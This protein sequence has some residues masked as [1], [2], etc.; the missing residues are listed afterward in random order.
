MP[1]KQDPAFEGHLAKT[2]QKLKQRE[3][4][5]QNESKKNKRQ[6]QLV[7]MRKDLE[8]F[9]GDLKN[10]SKRTY[11]QAKKNIL[12]SNAKNLDSEGPQRA[13]FSSILFSEGRPDLALAL[14]LFLNENHWRYIAGRHASFVRFL[15]NEYPPGSITMTQ[16]LADHSIEIIGR[17][18]TSEDM[19]AMKAVLNGKESV[20]LSGGIA[21]NASQIGWRGSGI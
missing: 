8:K 6:L 16:E 3:E 4:W 9:M 11:S 5:L 1:P 14:V 2:T 13:L 10:C 18:C 7:G 20:C 19:K 15:I 17:V 21:A 12:D